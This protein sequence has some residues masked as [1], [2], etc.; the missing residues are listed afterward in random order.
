M[1]A[2]PLL[3]EANDRNLLQRVDAL[4]TVP[5]YR[6]FIDIV[7][8]TAMKH[9]SF[10]EWVLL[11]H[12]SFANAETFLGAFRP[13]KGIGDE[14]MYYIEDADLRDAQSSPARIFEGLY[15][16]ATD[17]AA[18][19]PPVKIVAAYCVSVY[20]MTFL[21]GTRDYYGVDVDRCAR[22]KS[23]DPAPR[24][25]EV[26]IDSR[27]HARVRADYEQ[28]GMDQ[29]DSFLRLH[30]PILHPVRDIPDP[31]NVYRTLA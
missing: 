20:P 25:G 21:R 9:R 27:M 10:R 29:F 3:I 30:G 1:P 11:I 31:V 16:L 19:F 13:L 6:I 4:A 26:V 7:G 23:I 12:N 14:L 17:P 15:Q 8:S 24:Q 2:E 5:G 18:G 28:P 22:L